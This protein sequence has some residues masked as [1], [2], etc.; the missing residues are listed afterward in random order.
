MDQIVSERPTSGAS[1][2]ELAAQL[3]E[4]RAR[5]RRLTDDLSSEQLM[6]LKLDIV[7]PVLWEIGHVG[8]FHEYWT[9]RHSLGQHPLIERADD[10][11][12]SSTVAHDTRWSLDLPDRNGTFAYLAGV[13]ERQCEHLARSDF[14]EHARYFYELA[15]RHE[16]MHVEALTYMRETLAYPPPR[17]LGD[18]PL[19]AGGLAGD[20]AYVPGGTWR[21]GATSADGFIFDNEKWAHPVELNAFRIARAPI[22][23]RNYAA[24]VEAGGYRAREF[25]SAA[26]WMWRERERAER[27][28]Y[29]QPK[30]DGVW[31]WRRYNRT[32]VLPPDAPVVFV[33]WY[34][35]EAWCRWAKR[36]LPTETEW[37][38]ATIGEPNANGS[39]LSDVKRQWP[40]GDATPSRQHANLDFAFDGPTDVAACPHGDSAFGCRQIVGNVWE[41]TASD[42]T[43]FP[44]FSPDPYSDY[45][46]PWFGAR[47][48]L[49]GGA[50][51]TSARLARPTFRNFFPPDRNDVFAGF[52][53]CAA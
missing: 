9:L 19:P 18:Q 50:W 40:W 20:D 33:N 45:S 41:W 2:A 35:A 7:N 11:W 17:G 36:R 31:T 30:S 47:K 27:P 1:T 32:E 3:H 6:G 22:T 28:V 38:A 29:W 14:P 52:R 37:E 13:L 24:F 10:L 4:V 5:T 48:V 8:W 15:I 25:W 12:N 46:Q 51:A 49:R 42:F 39:R 23:N 21:L 26:G 44:G 16:D 43:P 53:T 34:E